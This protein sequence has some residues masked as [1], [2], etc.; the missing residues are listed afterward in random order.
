MLIGFG[1]VALPYLRRPRCSQPFRDKRHGVSCHSGSALCAESLSALT[2]SI[3]HPSHPRTCR[4]SQRP[5][6]GEGQTTRSVVPQWL[7]NPCGK[8]VRID[9]EHYSAEPPAHLSRKSTAC[10]WR[11][12]L[13]KRPVN[14]CLK[15]NTQSSMKHTAARRRRN[16]SHNAPSLRTWRVTLRNASHTDAA[17]VEYAAGIVSLDRDR[18]AFRVYQS[19]CS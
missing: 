4:G 1:V 7:R 17:K 12:R 5:A 3:A 6:A 8:P 18:S 2:T 14:T 19:F 11:G 13:S 15:K 10:C 9:H 16:R